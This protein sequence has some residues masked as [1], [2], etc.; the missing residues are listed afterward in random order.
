MWVDVT[1]ILGAYLLGSLPHLST[2]AKL[3]GIDLEGDYHISLWERAGPLLCFTGILGEFAKGAIPVL[4]ARSLGFSLPIIAL[5]GL[6]AVSGQ[7]WPIFSRFDGEKGNTIGLAMAAALAPK[8]TLIA[9][10]PIVIAVI[11]RVG[12]R[13][14]SARR[15]TDHRSAIGG[16]PSRI[17]P[18][19]MATGFFIL[20]FA[21][22]WLGKPLEIIMGCAAL[23][24]LIMLRRLT[25]G[26]RKDLAVSTDIKAI[27]TRRLL[28]DRATAKWRQQPI[29]TN[30]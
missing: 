12:P 3:R 8:S 17:L 26:I 1:L 28:Y 18:L 9:L 20:P 29:R 5:V 13:L 27:I 22:W 16:V 24:I 19:G 2:L 25:A 15:S 30:R 7:M 4:I 11:L 10:V 14:L 6:A 23:F 21:S